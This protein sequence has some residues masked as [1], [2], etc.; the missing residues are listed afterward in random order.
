MNTCLRLV[1]GVALAAALVAAPGATGATAG[2]AGDAAPATLED[3]QRLFYGGHF[4]AAAALALS[5]RTADPG[6][7]AASELRGSALHFQIKRV[8]GTPKDRERAWKSCALCPDLLSEFLSETN[9]GRVEARARL[10]RSPADEEALFFLGKLDLNVLWLYAGTLGRKTGWSEYWEGRRSL[11][12]VLRMNPDHARAR[13]A[14]A[15][16]DY[17][18]DTKVP[19]GTRWLLGGGDKKRGLQAV[20]DLALVPGPP[21]VQTEAMF[22]LWDMQVRERSFTEAVVTARA[23]ARDFPENVELAKFLSTYDPDGSR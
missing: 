7:L 6:N 10:K 1:S 9:L 16:I 2:Q 14:R 4:E 23:L 21:Y 5:L 12:A 18:V 3:A 22:A 11:D 19:W 20:R 13:L 17:I 15:W 8:F